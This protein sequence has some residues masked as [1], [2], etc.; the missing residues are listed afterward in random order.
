V[1]TLIL[2]VLAGCSEKTT[3]KPAGV[4]AELACKDTIDSVYG[5]PGALPAEAGAIIKC[6][7]EPDRSVADLTA[8]LKMDPRFTAAALT[9][10]AHVYRVLY[11]TERGGPSPAPG[12]SSA[13]VMLPDKP[14]AA[15]LPIVVVSH[16][17]RGQGPKCAPSRNDPAASSVQADFPIIA[18]PFVGYGYAIIAPD[19]AGYANYGAPGNP[20]PTYG[21]ADDVGKSTL[22]GARALAKLIPSS[23]NDQT[24]VIGFSQGGHTALSS[25]TMAASYAPEIKLAG[26]GVFAPLWLSQ[27]SWG[28]LAGAPTF[29]PISSNPAPNAVALWYHYTHSALLDGQDHA[30]DVFRADKRDMVKSFVDTEC[31][32]QDDWAP[33]KAFGNLATDFFDMTFADAVGSFAAG[34]NATCPTDE[35]AKST[36]ELWYARYLADRP[37]VTG[38]AQNVPIQL[39]WGTTDTTIAYDRVTCAIDRLHSDN[40]S[41]KVC[42]VPGVD[43]GGAVGARVDWMANWIA[44]RALGGPEPAA[45]DCGGD[46]SAI[47]DP[48]GMK[49]M[50]NLIPPND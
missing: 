1:R 32:G 4:S 43:H 38:A 17:S 46:E 27:R 39:I 48:M 26:V 34:I 49:A 44:A 29:F 31:W 7:R 15:K 18:Y 6:A 8:S 42:V 50:C 3:P 21:A 25:L 13:L 40:A 10:G 16:G 20:P 41:L 37:H 23:I 12:Y 2:L 47:L 24:V 11:R 5:D 19:L 35:P 22:D 28:A 30:T 36:C 33:L 9:S 14:R 45:A